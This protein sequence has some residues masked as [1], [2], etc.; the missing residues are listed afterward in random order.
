MK[1]ILVLFVGI[2]VLGS[3]GCKVVEEPKVFQ[4]LDVRILDPCLMSDGQVDA[5]FQPFYGYANS[6]E[7]PIP[8]EE[9]WNINGIDV[10]INDH[11]S[12]APTK[13]VVIQKWDVSSLRHCLPKGTK[14]VVV[15]G[16]FRAFYP[17]GIIEAQLKPTKLPVAL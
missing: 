5:L 1:K 2:L 8:V 14:E 9:N 6:T 7:K 10:R 13:G 4:V 17:D 11:R 16:T 12:L 15:S 3:F